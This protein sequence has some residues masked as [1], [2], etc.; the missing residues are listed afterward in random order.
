VTK[1]DTT[2]LS[3]ITTI[4]DV[5]NLDVWFTHNGNRN[6]DINSIHLIVKH[7]EPKRVCFDYIVIEVTPLGGDGGGTANIYSLAI[8]DM[9]EDSDNDIVSGDSNGDIWLSSNGG[10]GRTWDTPTTPNIDSTGSAVRGL[11]VGRL[12]GDSKI[13]IAAGTD[14][15]EVYVYDN[16]GSWTRTQIDDVG[17]TIYELAVGDVDGDYVD[18]DV[19][20]A[21]GAG[22]LSGAIYYYENDGSWT[23]TE[24]DDTGTPVFCVTLG[25]IDA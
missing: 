20:I 4:N 19:V 18:D 8:G 12:V 23:R 14:G 2:L 10:D 9:D 5:L 11:G 17:D 7:G 3:E 21:T 24:V 6:V 1:S 25:D 13:D 16:D 15:G 22:Q